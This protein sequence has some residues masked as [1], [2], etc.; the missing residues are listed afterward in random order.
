MHRDSERTADMDARRL[1]TRWRL[2][3]PFRARGFVAVAYGLFESAGVEYVE[4]P[5][6][7]GFHARES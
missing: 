2:R 7:E 1:Q 3:R 4:L 6:W 5:L